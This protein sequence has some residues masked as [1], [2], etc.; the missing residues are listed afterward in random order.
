MRGFALNS[1]DA[2][3]PLKIINNILNKDFHVGNPFH[4][5]IDNIVKTK[6][7]IKDDKKP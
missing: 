3:I 2:M 1:I 5:K 6:L 4:I 7:I